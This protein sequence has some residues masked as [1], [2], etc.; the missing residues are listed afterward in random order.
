MR[1]LLFLFALLGCLN[2]AQAQGDRGTA[3]NAGTINYNYADLEKLDKLELTKIYIAKLN[4]LHSI[5]AYMPFH[6]L[7]PKNPNDLKIPDHNINSKSMSKLQGDIK[8]FQSTVDAS[9]NVLTPYADTVNIINGIV[10]LQ[11]TINKVELIGLGM[12]IFGY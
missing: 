1:F 2:F 12:L 7:E 3:N 5:L 6:K 11:T 10:F 9:L 8:D 4:R